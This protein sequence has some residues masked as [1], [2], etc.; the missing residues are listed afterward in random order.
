MPRFRHVRASRSLLAGRPRTQYSVEWGSHV[1]TRLGLD[2]VAT[3]RGSD[4]LADF[5]F[6]K[7]PAAESRC[8]QC[9]EYRHYRDPIKTGGAVQHCANRQ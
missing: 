5:A 9:A 3:A 7:F 2:P 6:H 4:L 8:H 1:A